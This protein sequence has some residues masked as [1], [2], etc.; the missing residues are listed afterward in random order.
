[1]KILLHFLIHVNAAH[2]HIS[3]FWDMKKILTTAL[4][5]GGV[6]GLVNAAL[7]FLLGSTILETPFMEP[8]STEYMPLSQFAIASGVFTVI[9]TLIGALILGVLYNRLQEKGVRIWKIVGIVFLV[10]YGLMPFVT[11]GLATFKAAILSNLLHLVA[12]IPALMLIPRRAG[13]E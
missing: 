10:L 11:P 1:V 6:A 13:L 4:T 9:L 5:I 7:A 8:G 12:G 2:L 3:L